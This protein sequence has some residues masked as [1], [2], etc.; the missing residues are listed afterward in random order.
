MDEEDLLDLGCQVL[1]W[2]SNQAIVIGQ[3]TR[4]NAYGRLGC[5]LFLLSQQIA[6][7][8]ET[9]APRQRLLKIFEI[10]NKACSR[11][12]TEAERY[13]PLKRIRAHKDSTTRVRENL[14]KE[15]QANLVNFVFQSP[16]YHTLLRL[17]KDCST[18]DE[19]DLL[20]MEE[21]YEDDGDIGYPGYLNETLHTQLQTYVTCHCLTGH[22][23]WTRVRLSTDRQNGDEDVSFEVIFKANNPPQEHPQPFVQWK[24]SVVKV[25]R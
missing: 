17:I 22:L 13:R 25:P 8:S 16:E 6:S 11:S 12:L 24:E 3:Q 10:V 21:R 18:V 1:P 20:S 4:N 19:T 14:I 7:I 2:I 5:E 23:E 15:T 9:A